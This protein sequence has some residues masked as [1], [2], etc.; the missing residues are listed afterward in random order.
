MIFQYIDK[1]L[2]ILYLVQVLYFQKN[3]SDS[4]TVVQ[5]KTDTFHLT[6]LEEIDH[7]GRV[8]MRGVSR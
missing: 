7:L 8:E 1:Y 5:M 4:A 2:D 6:I 3:V